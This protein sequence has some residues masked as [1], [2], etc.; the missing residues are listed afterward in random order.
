MI[1]TGTLGSSPSWVGI[2]NLYFSC[3]KMI[4][5]RGL[6]K[7]KRSSTKSRSRDYSTLKNWEYLNSPELGR[8]PEIKL[9][10][11]N[12]INISYCTCNSLC[13]NVR[14]SEKVLYQLASHLCSQDF[15]SCCWVRAVSLDNLLSIKIQQDI[16]SFEVK[17]ENKHVLSVF[18]PKRWELESTFSAEQYSINSKSIFEGKRWAWKSFRS[19]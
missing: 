15:E 18:F 9:Y 12:S 14:E 3:G 10:A 8:L 11:K 5:K 17:S 19:P 4:L 13:F 6:K 7:Q 1:Y 2:L 16:T